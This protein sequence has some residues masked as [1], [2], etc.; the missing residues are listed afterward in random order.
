MNR[1]TK[2]V[3]GFE[4]AWQ[5]FLGDTGFGWIA[6]YTAVNGDVEFNNLSVPSSGDVQTPLVGLSD[7]YNLV[8]FYDKNGLQARVAYNWRDKFLT[9]AT[10]VS[11]QPNNPL[12]V[13]DFGQ[14]D[15][16]ASYD[17]TER[18]TVFAEGINVLNETTRTVGRTSGYVNF[19]TQTGS[20]YNIGAR[21]T[22]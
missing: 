20:R 11:G 22:W 10:G 19:A 15:L 7:S 17:V 12:Y 16:S 3:D 6:N 8:G 14:V 13:E 9:S 21:Y 1:D 5:H 4:I 18:V 2:N